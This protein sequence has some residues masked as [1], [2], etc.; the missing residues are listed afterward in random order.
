MSDPLVACGEVAL[1]KGN[2]VKPKPVL[3]TFSG[4]WN[5]PRYRFEDRQI[6][7]ADLRAQVK[8]LGHGPRNSTS[9]RH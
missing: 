8:S 3:G 1:Y 4:F 5:L 7:I 6:G 2:W 9:L